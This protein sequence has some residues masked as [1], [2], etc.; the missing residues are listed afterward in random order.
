MN[1]KFY[2][3]AR[4]IYEEFEQPNYWSVIKGI[5]IAWAIYLFARGGLTEGI[6]LTLDFSTTGIMLMI[7]WVR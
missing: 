2:L 7:I 4:W 5:L 6:G 3:G 1:R